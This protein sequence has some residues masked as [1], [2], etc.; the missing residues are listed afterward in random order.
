MNNIGKAPL[1]FIKYMLGLN[2]PV[3]QTSINEQNTI[4]KYCKNASIALEIGTY[5]GVNTVLIA[6]NTPT[7]AKVFTIDPFFKGKLNICYYKKIAF[8]LLLSEINQNQTF[9]LMKCLCTLKS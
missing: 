8:N 7:Y 5:E 9:K 2:K 3:T 6:K 1:H 4:I